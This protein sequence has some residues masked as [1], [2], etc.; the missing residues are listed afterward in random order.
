MRRTDLVLIPGIGGHPRFHEGFAGALE[1]SYRVHTAAHADFFSTP[2]P[3]FA[4]H[5]AYWR[6]RFDEAAAAGSPPVIVGISFGAHLAL[7]LWREL[8]PGAAGGV[9]L[10]SYWPLAGWQRA[11]LRWLG[12]LPRFGTFAV[13]TVCLR[14]SEWTSQ[15]RAE[16]R[17]QRRELYDDE[18]TARRRL[19][20]RLVSLAGA[21][22]AP[23]NAEQVGFVY[24]SREP[25]LRYARRRFGRQPPGRTIV[26]AGTHSVSLAGT[27]E[28]TAAIDQLTAPHPTGFEE[29][30]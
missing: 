26:V 30:A 14:W 15:D 11:G 9:V 12:R 1:R 23:T 22:S 10:V 21:P 8:P 28:L 4:A 13:G 24:A 7:A 25:A 3:D 17:R 6:A 27:A 20:A 18:R 2:C 5:T 19:W 16:L 29:Q